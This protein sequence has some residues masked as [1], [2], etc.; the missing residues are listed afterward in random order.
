LK[1]GQISEIWP[2][3][4]NLATWPAP[5]GKGMDMSELRAHHRMTPEQF[6]FLLLSSSSFA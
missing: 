4:A 6:F 5:A 3:K 1:R 2:K